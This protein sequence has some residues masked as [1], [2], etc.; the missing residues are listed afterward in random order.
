MDGMMIVTLGASEQDIEVARSDINSVYRCTNLT[1]SFSH[2]LKLD[3][4][5]SN[6]QT[7]YFAG[8]FL[9]REI[10]RKIFP[11]SSVHHLKDFLVNLLKFTLFCCPCSGTSVT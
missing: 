8:Q 1:S 11:K 6:H 4:N 7:I 2:L 5:N 10:L 9:R 3:K